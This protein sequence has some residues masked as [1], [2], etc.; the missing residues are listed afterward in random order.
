MDNQNLLEQ[1][2]EIKSRCEEIKEGRGAFN[3]DPIEHANNTI[4]NM[5]DLAEQ[6]VIQLGNLIKNLYPISVEIIN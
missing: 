1:L 6:N 2:G 5:K 3:I 4:E